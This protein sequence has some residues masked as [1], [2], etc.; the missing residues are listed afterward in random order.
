MGIGGHNMG[1][2]RSQY[3]KEQRDEYVARWEA[4]NAETGMRVSAFARREGLGEEMLRRWVRTRVRP[5]GNGGHGFVKVGSIDG[6]RPSLISMEYYGARMEAHDEA[7]LLM[8][9]RCLR[10]ASR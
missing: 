6:D 1:H 9:M 4:E 5:T 8:A 2:G 3:T 7:S 10:L